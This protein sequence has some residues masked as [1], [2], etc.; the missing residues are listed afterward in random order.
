MVSP[1]EHVEQA[2]TEKTV[3]YDLG[4]NDPA[5]A[6]DR[7]AITSPDAAAEALWVVLRN[8]EDREAAAI[9]VLDTK[10][11]LL[12]T[13]LLSVGSID[14]TF[15]TPRTVFRIALGQPTVAAIVIGH[16][17]PSGDPE[18][19]RDDEAIT[20]RMASAGELIGI[21]L[22]DHVVMGNEPEHWASLARRGAI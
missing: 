16:R 12:T 21:G 18:P 6:D 17:H 7:P 22:L 8:F 3:S 1:T 9:L 11:R 4:G 14:H 15:M 10:H 2:Q 20:R 13:E 19:S 5:Y